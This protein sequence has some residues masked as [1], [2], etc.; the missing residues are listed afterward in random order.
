MKIYLICSVGNVSSDTKARL[1]AYT[2]WLEDKGHEVY[3][4]NR[5]A[6]Q[7]ASSFDI[8]NQNGMAI[9]LADEIHIIYD[10]ASQESHFD[11]GIVFAYDVLLGYKKRIRVVNYA[12]LGYNKMTED[13]SFYRM[14]NEWTH[15]QNQ[16]EKLY[17]CQEEVMDLNLDIYHQSF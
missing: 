8:C 3:L 2:N 16:N 9:A 5:D 7:N 12:G 17:P 15:E 11:M 6:D 10:K 13:K 1:E 14:L 4:P